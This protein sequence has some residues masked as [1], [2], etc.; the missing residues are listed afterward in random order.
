MPSIWHS[1]AFQDYFSYSQLGVVQAKYSSNDSPFFAAQFPQ[2]YHLIVED[3]Q[4]SKH[5]LLSCL[6]M[7]PLNLWIFPVNI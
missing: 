2:S 7:I 6:M 1:F 4:L 5:R 3:R